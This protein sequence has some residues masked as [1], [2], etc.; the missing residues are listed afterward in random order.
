[1]VL[2]VYAYFKICFGKIK[3][4]G[5]GIYMESK[6]IFKNGSNI[7]RTLAAIVAGIL[8]DMLYDV[9]T[10]DHFEGNITDNTIKINK[11]NEHSILENICSIIILFVILWLILSYVVPTIIYI[12]SS[13]KTYNIPKTDRKKVLDTYKEFKHEIIELQNQIQN[14]NAQ[15]ECNYLLIFSDTCR[16]ILELHKVFCSDKEKNKNIVKSSFRT[17]STVNDIGKELSSYEFLAVLNMAKNILELSYNNVQH[18]ADDLS[19]YDYTCILSYWEDL[20]HLPQSFN[21][22]L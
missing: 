7:A 8:T 20:M 13:L 4:M 2:K 3:I 11:V 12:I 15:C 14:M 19:T 16:I 6:N 5:G 17:G 22:P 18:N 1:M 10:E 21:L 9:L